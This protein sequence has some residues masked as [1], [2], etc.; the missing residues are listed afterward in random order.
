MGL[1]FVTSAN[2]YVMILASLTFAEIPNC[3]RVIILFKDQVLFSM[4]IKKYNIYL[5]KCVRD[6]RYL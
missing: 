4:Q 5:I 3:P 2:R 1:L 6:E